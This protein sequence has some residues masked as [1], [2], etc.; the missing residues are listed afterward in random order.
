MG[1]VSGECTCDGVVAEGV[2]DGK[3]GIGVGFGMG[4]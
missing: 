2:S 3:W 1:M 4:E